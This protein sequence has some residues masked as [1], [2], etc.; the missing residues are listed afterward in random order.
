MII[1][2]VLYDYNGTKGIRYRRDNEVQEIPMAP[3]HIQPSIDQIF[4]YALSLKTESEQKAMAIDYIKTTATDEQK[5]N[6]IELYPHWKVGSDYIVGDELRYKEKLYRVIQAHTS[7]SDWPPT[8]TPALFLEISPKGTI[9]NWKAPTGAH[10]AYN[11][12]DQVIYTDGLVYKSKI[13]A[14]TTVPG[15]DE[16]YNRYWVMT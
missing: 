9:P 1:E 5:L 3:D 12:G 10:D 15:A 11:I 13:N 4:N 6:L 14:N 2:I 8:A 16:P 7:Q